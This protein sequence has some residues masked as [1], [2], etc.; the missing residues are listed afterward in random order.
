MRRAPQYSRHGDPHDEHVRTVTTWRPVT[1]RFEPRLAWV[2][3]ADERG[4]DYVRPSGG[5]RSEPRASD[6]SC[7]LPE[8]GRR[9]TRSRSSWRSATD[10]L[11][12]IR[13]QSRPAGMRDSVLRQGYRTA[14]QLARRALVSAAAPGN[15]APLQGALPMTAVCAS[16]PDRSVKTTWGVDSHFGPPAIHT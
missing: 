13:V 10:P 2:A 7:P 5:E 9:P 8:A 4:A 12:G 14:R 6:A 1:Q 11:V 3:Q 15:G 16:W